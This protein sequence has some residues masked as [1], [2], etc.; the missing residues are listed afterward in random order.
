[1]AYT[2]ILP[3]AGIFADQAP[4]DASGFYVAGSNVRFVQ[5]RA[6]TISGFVK[7]TSETTIGIPRA[8]KSWAQIDGQVDVAVASALAIEIGTGGSL[9]DITP[10]R[11]TGTLS[12]SPFATVNGS[13]TVTV[14]HTSHGA[15]TNDRVIFTNA[16]AV[17][18]LTLNGTFS[19]TKINNDTYTIAAG[20]NANGTGSGGGTPNYQYLLTSGPVDSTLQYGWGVGGWS[21]GT[22]G[23]PRT[24]SDTVLSARTWSLA[25]YGEDLLALHNDSGVIYYWDATNG[26]TTRAIPLAN[27]PTANLLV[28]SPETRHI[29]TFGAGGDPLKVQWCAQDAITDWTPSATNDAG[30]QRLIDGSEIRAVIRSR[31]AILVLTDTAVY[32]MT[33]IGGEY[34]FRFRRIGATGPIC[35]PQAIAERDGLVAWMCVDGTFM[36]YDG[37]LRQLACPVRR[38]VFDDINL[39]QR[40]KIN[41]GVNGAFTEIWWS[42]PSANSAEP[43]KVVVWAYGQGTDVW[44]LSDDLGRTAWESAGVISAPLATASN[45]LIYEHE[46]GASADG[47]DLVTFVETGDQDIEEGNQ[48]YHI[49]DC[50]P[51]LDM[52]GADADNQVDLTLKAR[53]YPLGTQTTNGP[54]QIGPST[55]KVSTRATG[56]QIAYR[57]SSSSTALFWRAG[58][59]RFDVEV[60]GGQR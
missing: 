4:A 2:S 10:S 3:R 37:S 34:V 29:V 44:W 13:P 57:L 60:S 39:V 16:T 56:R 58:K 21:E 7:H 51:D 40:V 8:L 38:H 49:N 35:G 20:S 42:Y 18:G 15:I 31:G 45:R 54:H 17:N 25:P 14:T 12:A 59:Q 41:A 27:A 55:Q 50:I 5:G 6:E 33:Y 47:L 23:T 28:V 19:I 24:A 43:D 22:W 53:I 30:D 36:A 48:L 26:T 32:E 9:S 1:M 11:S 46:T 52:T